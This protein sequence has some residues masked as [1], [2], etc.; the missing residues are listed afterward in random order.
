MNRIRAT[1]VVLLGLLGACNGDPKRIESADSAIAKVKKD[2]VLCKSPSSRSALIMAA[3]NPAP[4]RAGGAKE[5]MVLVKGGLFRMGSEA[6]ADSKP[7]HSVQ[8]KGFY[9]DAHEVTNAQY[10]AFVKATGYIT[11]AEQK[12]DPK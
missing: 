10:A 11:V 12:L 8:V 2:C 4:T 9:M 7:V 5:E 6:F 3:Y 1:G